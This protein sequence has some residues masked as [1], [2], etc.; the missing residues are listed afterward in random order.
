[1]E[2]NVAAPIY[3]T[4]NT[5]VRIRRADQATPL[6]PQTLA[7]TSRTSGGRSVRIVHSRT[8]AT[9]LLVI[10]VTMTSSRIEPATFRLAQNASTNY[11]TMCP[12]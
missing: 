4:E 9:E 7:L 3:K 12:R 10:Y 8:K 2:E 1:L 6:Y 11:A 5:A